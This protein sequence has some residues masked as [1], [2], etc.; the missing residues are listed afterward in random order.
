MDTGGLALGL[1][2]AILLGTAYGGGIGIATGLAVFVWY[3]AK[4]RRA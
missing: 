1:I 3:H 2:A 4:Q